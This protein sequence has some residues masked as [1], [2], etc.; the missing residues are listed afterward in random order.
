MEGAMAGA[1]GTWSTSPRFEQRAQ[2]RG[3][4]QEAHHTMPRH[5]A[6]G[7]VRP[8]FPCRLA[9]PDL[10]GVDWSYDHI[11]VWS[12]DQHLSMARLPVKTR[13]HGRL[14]DVIDQFS[15]AM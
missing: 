3:H 8:L 4:A 9:E 12:L 14:P 10:R 1:A 5:V 13:T 7:L 6:Q 11:I 2:C 15:R